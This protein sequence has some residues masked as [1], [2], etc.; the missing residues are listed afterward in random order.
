MNEMTEGREP[1]LI[2]EI[3]QD[4][5]SL[6][7][8]ESPCQAGLGVTGANKCFNTFQTCQ[9]TANYDRGDLTLRF[10]RPQLDIPKE[11]NAIPSLV[12]ASTVPTKL[13]VGGGDRN[14]EP[15]GQRAACT[16]VFQDH[17]YSDLFVDKYVNERPTGDAGQQIYNPIERGTLWTKWLRRNPYYQNRQ[18]RIIEGYLGQPIEEMRT[19][20]YIIQKIDGPDDNGRV[21]ITA[22]DIL[23]L[24]DDD[25]A[26]APLAN[27]GE[28]SANINATATT[29]SVI[30]AETG[31]Y[32][33][34]NGILRIGDEVLRYTT[35]T[36]VDDVVTF[37]GVTRGTDNTPAAP[38]DAGDTVQQCLA[39]VNANVWDVARDLLVNY[40]NVPDQFIPFADWIAEGQIWLPQ[41]SVTTLITEPVGVTALLGELAEQTLFYIWWDERDQQVKFRA[42]RPPSETPTRLTDRNNILA[43]SIKTSVDPD[44]RVSEIWVYYLPIVPT[45]RLDTARN[46]RRLRV[47]VDPSASSDNEYGE[48]RIK[49]IFSRWLESD[50]QTVTLATRYLARYRNNPQFAT[51]RLDAKDRAL[52]T[53]DIADLQS[54]VYVGVT[55]MIE[56]RRFQVIS[57]EE[58][59][60]GEVVEYKLQSFEFLG[61]NFGRW[62][63]EFAPDYLDATDEQ[64]TQGGWWADDDGFMSNGDEAYKWQ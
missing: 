5:C 25:R 10:V 29:L 17:P 21:R 22:K 7:Y 28:L 51:V 56:D 55:G 18:I 15:L 36:Q 42:L 39:Y 3:D 61:T 59:T 54:R 38:H 4:F 35:A 9:D 23:K 63:E 19:R 13:N 26:E 49:K 8:G 11:W 27:R 31:E 48:R 52:W 24:A 45:E 16:V 20:H 43:G 41:F 60:P 33:A 62:M 37:T 64:K 46:Y 12:S 1:V 40:G 50:A 30:R 2:V 47:R 57:A 53:G 34:S 14:A 6:N 32:Q 58:I 44:Q